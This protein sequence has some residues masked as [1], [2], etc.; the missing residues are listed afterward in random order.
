MTR[1]QGRGGSAA[2]VQQK[3]LRRQCF[4]NGLWEV[5]LTDSAYDWRQLLKSLPEGT[6][7]T[8]V[9]TGVVK[10]SFRLL[11]N[12]RDHNYV[13]KD[14]SERHVFQITCADGVRWLLHFHKN[15]KMDTPVYIP[16]P[17]PTP[18]PVLHSQSMNNAGGEE[19]PTWYAEDILQNS[20]DTCLQDNVPIGRTE[21]CMALVTILQRH[22]PQPCVDIT[23]TTAFPWHRWLRNVTQ[24]REI[25]G[26]GI[27]KVFA[28]CLTSIQQ[29]QI[30]FCHPDDT[31]TCAKPKPKTLEYE[32]LTG[33]R[34]SQTFAQA[35]AETASWLQTRASRQ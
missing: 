12:V 22:S 20:M 34:D 25:I 7:K 24:N 30:V 27:V 3:H 2:N 8:L 23:T 31:Y 16:P 18:T 19:C 29:A 33:W 11:Q 32:Q 14:T 28:L 10:F 21:V 1:Q 9:G 26:C 17:S 5:D 15:G 13:K 4:D 6:S 35:P